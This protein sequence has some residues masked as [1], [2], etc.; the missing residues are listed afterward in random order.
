MTDGLRPVPATVPWV[1][2]LSIAA[3]CLILAVGAAG[4]DRHHR[5]TKPFV[6]PL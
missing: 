6:G 2:L 1:T 4:S 3:V 5:L